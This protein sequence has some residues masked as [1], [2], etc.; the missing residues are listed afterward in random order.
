MGV[1]EGRLEDPAWTALFETLAQR[2][3]NRSAYF[4]YDW[5]VAA[6]VLFRADVGSY[7]AVQAVANEH[8]RRGGGDFP[9]STPEFVWPVDEEWVLNTDPDLVS[10]FVACDEGLANTILA[11]PRLEVLAVTLKSRIDRGAD[12]I[13]RR[14]ST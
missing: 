14:R 9:A 11:H 12:R 3:A 1:E 4:L 7:G 8:L 13:N 2:S 10:T 5:T 6:A